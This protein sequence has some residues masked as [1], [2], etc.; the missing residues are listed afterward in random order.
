MT[1]R[2]N[3]LKRKIMTEM[4][5]WTYYIAVYILTP[6]IKIHYVMLTTQTT[7]IIQTMVVT[8]KAKIKFLIMT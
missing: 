5:F 3:F 6:N 1:L 8:G 4:L 7:S 2:G